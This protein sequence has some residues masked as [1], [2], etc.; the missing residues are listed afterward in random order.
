MRRLAG[1]RGERGTSAVR[2]DSTYADELDPARPPLVVSDPEALPFLV[3]PDNVVRY[4]DGDVHIL[5][6]R[7]Y[8]H[9]V[10]FV[11]CPDTEAVAE[12][13]EAMVTQSEGPGFCAGYAM[14]QAARLAGGGSADEQRAAL[15]RAGERLIATRPTNNHIRLAVEALLAEAGRALDRGEELE[16]AL[17]AIVR[18]DVVSRHARAEALG[19]AGAELISDGER[20]L[21]HCWA[22]NGI[23]Y[24]LMAARDSGKEL[25]VTCTETRPYL[26]GARLTAD[27]VAD[28]GLPVTIVTDGM[29]GHAMAQGRATLFTSGADRVTMDGHVVNKVGTMPIAVT[30]AHFGVPYYPLCY[31]PDRRAPGAADVPIEERDPATVLTLGGTRLA[32][33]KAGA[34]YPAF[35]AT[36]PDCVRAF[37][38]DRGVFAPQDIARYLDRPT[39]DLADD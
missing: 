6:R 3:R 20:V 1:W 14:V 21:T 13:I 30:A 5:D 24:L 34:W 4:E 35:D 39:P 25:S 38:T 36:P 31:G 33:T 11:R 26:Q 23:V 8:P 17:L 18:E 28:L 37:I 9:E 16:P 15:R 12:A 29:A 32:T 2:G 27:A 7:V 22:E 10:R 19:R